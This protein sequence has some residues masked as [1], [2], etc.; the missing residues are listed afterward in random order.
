MVSSIVSFFGSMLHTIS[1]IAFIMRLL[2]SLI[3]VIYSLVLSLS[4]STLVFAISLE[5]LI[6]LNEL[7]ISSVRLVA[8]LV[9][10]LSMALIFCVRSLSIQDSR[11]ITAN[12]IKPRNHQVLQ[13]GGFTVMTILA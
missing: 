12:T 8:I 10:I 9:R 5:M 11:P 13:N 7:L 1:Y 2:V 4:V 3:C 6:V